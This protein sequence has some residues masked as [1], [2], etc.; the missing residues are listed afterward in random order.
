MKDKSCSQEV[1]LA[2]RGPGTLASR[3]PWK[4][5]ISGDLDASV[6]TLGLCVLF[7]RL[8]DPPSIHSPPI[9]PSSSI[10]GRAIPRSVGGAQSVLFEILQELVTH[11]WSEQ[12]HAGPN[13]I[14]H[15]DM[16]L[17][18]CFRLEVRNNHRPFPPES[19][20]R[21]AS[22]MLPP[23]PFT[24]CMWDFRRLYLDNFT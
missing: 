12:V 21:T 9:L 18:L 20:N 23:L 5:F 15:L 16:L 24:A 14:I 17:V 8:K 11:L 13:P 2:G 7:S 22:A 1:H 10:E 4:H 19:R 6:T 3:F